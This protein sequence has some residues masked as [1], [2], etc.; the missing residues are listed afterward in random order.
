MNWESNNNGITVLSYN[1]GSNSTLCGIQQLLEWYKLTIV[2]V[3]E[4]CISTDQFN[5]LL[6]KHYRGM[7]NI[8]PSNSRKPG[9]AIA[10]LSNLE[11]DVQNVVQCRIQT[12]NL[13]NRSFINV[14]APSG[15]QGQ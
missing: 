2:F 3:Q 4:I 9:T 12:I 11:V 5:I 6:G 13:F 7:C 15:T 10:W 14:Y 8:D 1:V